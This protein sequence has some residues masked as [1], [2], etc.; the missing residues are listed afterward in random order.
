[1]TVIPDS[2]EPVEEWRTWLW[3]GARLTSHNGSGWKPG[4]PMQATCAGGGEVLGWKLIRCGLPVAKAREYAAS[5]NQ[6]MHNP[7]GAVPVQAHLS[8]PTVEPPD[9]Y[10]YALDR[11]THEAPHVGCTCGIYTGRQLSDCPAGVISGK[12]KLWGTIIPGTKGSRAQ[13][14]YPSELH[15]PAYLAEDPGVLAYGVP[16]VIA[17]TPASVAAMREPSARRSR[18][19]LLISVGANLGACAFNLLT[20]WL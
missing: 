3:D 4:E 9:G 20:H 16:L 1:M 11:Q 13:F 19:I 5:H 6:W 14:A 17:E 15:V 8:Y 18:R 7:F 2:I 10:G 12:V